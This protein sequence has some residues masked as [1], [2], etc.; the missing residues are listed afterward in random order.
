MRGYGDEYEPRS[1]QDK[2]KKAAKW[3]GIG[4]A[5]VFG[6]AVV[7]DGMVNTAPDQVRMVLR[8]GD[9]VRYTDQGLS[10][11]IPLIET[12]Y[13]QTTSLQEYEIPTSSI[14]LQNGTVTAE[15]VQSSAFIQFNGTREEREATL[16]QMRERMPDFEERISSLAEAALR[17]TVRLT[18]IAST[19][20]EEEQSVTSPVR[21]GA[22][23]F[24]DSETVGRRVRDRL[25]SSLSAIIPGTVEV[26]GVTVPRLQV[27]EYRIGNFEF[28]RD[29]L[30]RRRSIADARANAE[31]ARFQE[32]QA[33]R[34]ANAA[35]RQAEGEK[36]AEI[37]RAQGAAEGIR[38]RA[39]AEAE[40]LEARVEAAGGADALRAQTLAEAWNGETPD[41]VGGE[42]V[43]VDG[44][45]APGTD[46]T[47]PIAGAPRP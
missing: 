14:A 25:Q 43:I 22:I 1:K 10:F 40:G 39:L 31:S 45:F 33:E 16:A 8:F 6:I 17:D 28:D 7:S 11:K 18:I 35:I 21:S 26:G 38:L 23:N 24:L 4:L 20:E 37:L 29:Y 19:D 47:A 27:T 3:A 46:I 42:G 30:D 36:Q 32:A 9:P 13:T 15:Q 41:V 44:R 34:I 5:A 2:I 12:L